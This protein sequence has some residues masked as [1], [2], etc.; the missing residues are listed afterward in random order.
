MEESKH[1]IA[2]RHCLDAAVV[3]NVAELD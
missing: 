2:G 1:A 3:C